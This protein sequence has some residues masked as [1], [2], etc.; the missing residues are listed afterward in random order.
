MMDVSRT[1]ITTGQ[2]RATLYS[3]ARETE[4]LTGLLVCFD[5]RCWSLA[6]LQRMKEHAFDVFPWKKGTASD[7]G[8]N[9]FTLAIHINEDGKHACSATDTLVGLLL[10]TTARTGRYSRFATLS[11]SFPTLVVGTICRLHVFT[12]LDEVLSDDWI[13][14]VRS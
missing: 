5:R 1:S 11:T 9:L 4:S 10:A 7:G 8:E 12:T 2:L 14:R 3:I 6:L 13:Y